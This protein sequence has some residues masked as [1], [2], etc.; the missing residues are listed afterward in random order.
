MS[1]ERAKAMIREYTDAVWNHADVEAMSRFYT[2]DYVH[3]DA[4]R[5]E[6]TTLDGYRHWARELHGGMDPLRVAI[7]DLIADAEGKVVKR[8]TATG[9]HAGELAGIPASGRE[10]S[11]SGM[12][13]YRIVGDRI[14]ESWYVYDLFGLLQQLGAIPNAQESPA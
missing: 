11:F 12:T 1:A 3:H 5:P 10:L 8:W 13:S 14:A 2:T 9:R 6:I 7:D 4:S